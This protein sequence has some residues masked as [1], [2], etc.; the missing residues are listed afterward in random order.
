MVPRNAVATAYIDVSEYRDDW[1]WC[2][3]LTDLRQVIQEKYPSF[4]DADSWSGNEEYVILTNG[5]AQVV[6]CTYMDLASVSVEPRPWQY[7]ESPH[8]ALAWCE[9]IAANFEA[10]LHKR[11]SNCYRKQGTM[12]NGVGVFQRV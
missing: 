2:D 8:M 7:V 10:H 3:F 12:S 11:Y 6:I 1:E 4:E 9:Q 5:H